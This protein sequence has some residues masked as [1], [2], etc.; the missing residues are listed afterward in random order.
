MAEGAAVR[1][2]R[3][4]VV[5]PLPPPSGGIGTWVDA[6][7]ASTLAERHS[8][9]VLDTAPKGEAGVEPTSRFRLGRALSSFGR[10]AALRRELRA[11][12]PE[13]VHVH[14]SYY[15]ALVRDGLAVWLAHR[16]GARTILHLHGGDFPAFHAACPGVLR[17]L[18][19]AVLGRCD[20]VIA[21]KATM[22][23]AGRTR[24]QAWLFCHFSIN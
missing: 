19:G 21:L 24:N 1:A 22:I 17:P 15:W 11:F 4:L 18:V 13:I 9:R 14:T 2:G 23:N 20:V 12:R 5:G 7:R 6:L 8:L 10:L 3:I 16:A